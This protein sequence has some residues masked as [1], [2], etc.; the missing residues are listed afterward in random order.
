M[1]KLFEPLNVTGIYVSTEMKFLSSEP[2]S[3]RLPDPKRKE[4]VMDEEDLGKNEVRSKPENNVESMPET[5][6]LT[7]KL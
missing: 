3:P 4:G 2:G 5:E 1:W 7:K 6:K